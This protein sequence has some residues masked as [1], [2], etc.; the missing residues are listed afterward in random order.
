MDSDMSDV[1]SAGYEGGSEGDGSIGDDNSA[2]ENSADGVDS[3]ED[4]S[5]HDDSGDDDSDD[6]NSDPA[7]HKEAGHDEDTDADAFWHKFCEDACAC[8][9]L[10]EE[11]RRPVTKD[12]EMPEE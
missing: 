6:Y 1:I 4:D 5:D 3:D 2:N 7:A 9:G 12:P 10:Q 8:E 11:I